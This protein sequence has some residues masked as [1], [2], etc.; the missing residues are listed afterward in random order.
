MN[1]KM[2]FRA[3]R[4]KEDA[5]NYILNITNILASSEHKERFSNTWVTRKIL[6]FILVLKSPKYIGFS[7]F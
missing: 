7:V 4:K 6:F 5:V 3:M 2:I 1:T